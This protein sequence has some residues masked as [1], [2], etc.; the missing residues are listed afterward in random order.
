MMDEVALLEG[1]LKHYSPTPP[2]TVEG[3]ATAHST[4]A[5]EYLVEQL[6]LEGF[7]GEVDQAGNAVASRGSGAHEV[8]LLGHIDTVPGFI[9]VCLDGDILRGRGAVDAKG[10]LA[11]FAS[12]A[13][14]VVIP[15]GW[16][17]TVVGADAE[18][19]DSHGAK[20]IRSHYLPE[21]VVIGEPSGWERV[22][23][24][25]KG[26]AW[27]NYNVVRSVAHSAARGQT[28]C[29]SAVNYWNGVLAAAAAYNSDKARVFDQLT[30]T[31][32]G[33]S[34]N[35]EEFSESACMK[36]GM[37]LPPGMSVEETSALLADLAVE[38]GEINLLDGI[39]AYK[40]VKNTP[41]VRAFLAAIRKSGG[42]PGFTLKTGT[43]DMNLVGPAWNCPIL[44]YGP[45][46]SDLDH[47]PAEHIHISEYL[48]SIDVLTHVLHLVMQP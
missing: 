45:G 23:L 28:A 14:R 37:R 44:A 16:K 26:S 22:T 36:I 12:A 18:E 13:A 10:P 35:F 48:V 9:P 8:M 5:A 19:G 29:E 4:S 15:P 47:T 42:Q 27:F 3:S 24:G 1:L 20:F 11:C 40:G 41:L 39:S 33:M 7:E 34:S 2:Q 21:M 17:V 6:Q 30:P 46:D 43:S 38:G 31:L 32:R 25:Y